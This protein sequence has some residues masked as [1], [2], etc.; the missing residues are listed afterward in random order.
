MMRFSNSALN[1]SS[2]SISSSLQSSRSNSRSSSS[3]SLSVSQAQFERL[4][5]NSSKLTNLLSFCPV[6][7][8]RLN[9]SENFELLQRLEKLTT[10]YNVPVPVILT[11]WIGSGKGSGSTFKINLSDKDIDFLNEAI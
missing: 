2:S 3:S 4:K 9:L 6:Q 8:E 7:Q 10:K 1:S 11:S 5:N